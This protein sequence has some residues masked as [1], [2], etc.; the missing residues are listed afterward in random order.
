MNPTKIRKAIVEMSYKA[1]EG[2]IASAFSIVEILGVLY[3]Y[4][5]ED[6]DRFILSK[7]HGCLALYAVLAEKG[8]LDKKELATFAQYDSILGGHPD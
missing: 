2:H 1:Q 3:D 6:E 8:L 5:L 4:V 7:G